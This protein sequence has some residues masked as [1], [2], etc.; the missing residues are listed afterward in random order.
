MPATSHGTKKSI[1]P[2][3]EMVVTTPKTCQRNCYQTK[4]Q[5][6]IDLVKKSQ[7]FSS[8]PFLLHCSKFL[9]VLKIPGEDVLQ[10]A[11][12]ATC[13]R[14]VLPSV[15]SSSLDLPSSRFLKTYSR[16]YR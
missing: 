10:I 16:L 1:L 15:T 2:Q 5:F 9:I 12:L 11:Q 13:K 4:L 14:V 7:I 6:Y 3:R 8:R